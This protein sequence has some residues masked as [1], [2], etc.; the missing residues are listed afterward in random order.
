MMSSRSA[1][2][3]EA[4]DTGRCDPPTGSVQRMLLRRSI[5]FTPEHAASGTSGPG[6]WI[7]LDPLQ[8]SE[9]DQNPAVASAEACDAMSAAAHRDEQPV[10]AGEVDR[11]H[12][13][14][15]AD[16]LGDHTGSFFVHAI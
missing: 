5:E 14:R 1:A 12:D 15:S 4:A 7:N 3:R 9:I 2:R 10:L 6:V 16:A 13:V 8:P 11:R